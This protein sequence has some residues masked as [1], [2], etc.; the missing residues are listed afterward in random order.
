MPQQHPQPYAQAL[1]QIMAKLNPK[2]LQNPMTPQ[3]TQPS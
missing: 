1:A 2:T 3:G